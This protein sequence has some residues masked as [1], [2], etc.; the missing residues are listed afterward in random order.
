MLREHDKIQISIEFV[1]IEERQ[2]VR[3]LDTLEEDVN[4]DRQAHGKKA[5]AAKESA[6][7]LTRRGLSA[8]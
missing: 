7:G 8:V 2:L 1:S 4:R 5:F 3:D 6:P